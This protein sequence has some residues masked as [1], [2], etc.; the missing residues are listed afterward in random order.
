MY[1]LYTQGNVDIYGRPL[2]VV[3]LYWFSLLQCLL[4]QLHLDITLLYSYSQKKE[5]RRKEGG[6]FCFF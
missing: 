1:G 4:L 5:K 3:F 2:K 6:V